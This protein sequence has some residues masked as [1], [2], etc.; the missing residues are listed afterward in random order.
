MDISTK[1]A[2]QRERIP[3]HLFYQINDKPPQKNYIEQH[4]KQ[5]KSGELDIQK[6]I[7]KQL[8]PLIQKEL[9]ELFK[10]LQLN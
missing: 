2:R 5:M 7:H 4:Q 3:D 9:T 1:I 8:E 10:G 6:E